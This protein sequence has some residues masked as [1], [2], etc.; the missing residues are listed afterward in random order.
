ML[1][2]LNI[3]CYANK[4]CFRNK[5]KELVTDISPRAI[6][7]LL[8]NICGIWRAP[9]DTGWENSNLDKWIAESNLCIG[10]IS[11]TY[12]GY[13]TES[14]SKAFEKVTFIKKYHTKAVLAFEVTGNSKTIAMIKNH[15]KKPCGIA[16]L[17]TSDCPA[18]VLV[19]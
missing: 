1:D 7:G 14:H 10:N 9:E 13:L 12:D 11:Y 17:G 4:A 16:Y 2:K 19:A 15:I 8:G 6:L 5:N 18:E 3:I